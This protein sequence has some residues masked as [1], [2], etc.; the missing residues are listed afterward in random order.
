MIWQIGGKGRTP[1]DT[2][3]G[4]VIANHLEPCL[5]EILTGQSAEIPAYPRL[6]AWSLLKKTSAVVVWHTLLGLLGHAASIHS[7][8]SSPSTT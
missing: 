3:L 8:S 4:Y 5:D 7:V 1:I 6:Y 2:V